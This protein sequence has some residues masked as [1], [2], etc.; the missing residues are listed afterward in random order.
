[1]MENELISVVVPTY[2]RKPELIKR[3]INSILL[4]TYKNIELLVIDDSPEEFEYRKDIEKFIKNLPD[5][6]KTFISEYNTS[7]DLRAVKSPL[8]LPFRLNNMNDLINRINAL[9]ID[10]LK[11]QNNHNNKYMRDS[12]YN[13]K[14]SVKDL[15]ELYMK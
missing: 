7:N 10:T 13:I 3:A 1:M 5:L 15:A 4:Q 11:R 6:K 2:K 12:S 9:P 14:N 8:A